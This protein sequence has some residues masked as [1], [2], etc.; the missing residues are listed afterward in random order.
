MEVRVPKKLN[1]PPEQPADVAA[2]RKARLAREAALLE[3]GRED[4]RAG[5]CI[6]GDD[7]DAW[8]EGLDGAEELR[9]PE[10]PND[11]SYR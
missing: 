7:V 6:G 1:S 8:L 11:R 4:I 10:R 9:V 5:R 2:R 3:E